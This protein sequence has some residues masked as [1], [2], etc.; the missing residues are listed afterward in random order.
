MRPVSKYKST[1]VMAVSVI[2]ALWPWY[3]L[4]QSLFSENAL[5]LTFPTQ[6]FATAGA[7]Y[8]SA[9]QNTQINAARL[10]HAEIPQQTRFQAKRDFELWKEVVLSQSQ[11]VKGFMN[12]AMQMT[13][14]PQSKAA[15]ND[16][17]ANVNA[18][19]VDLKSYKSDLSSYSQL[20]SHVEAVNKLTTF[21]IQDIHAADIHTYT[22]VVHD[23]TR[24]IQNIFDTGS[25]FLLIAIIA[26]FFTSRSLTRRSQ[27]IAKQSVEIEAAQRTA[28]ARAVLIGMVSH[29]L[30][31]PL[32]TL[33]ASLDLIRVQDKDSI[34]AATLDRAQA[35]LALMSNELRTL[36][37]FAQLTT[38]DT[39]E[40]SED[41][42]VSS[43]LRN[44]IAP[45]QDHA[46]QQARS[47]SLPPAID[48][49][50][51]SV[52]QTR[53][54]QIL[55]NFVSNALKYG[56]GGDIVLTCSLGNPL[57]PSSKRS[58]TFSVINQG[59]PISEKDSNMIWEPY[60]RIDKTS[61]KAPG[62]GLGL[63]VV[64]LLADTAGWDIGYTR[65]ASGQ[66]SFHV[67]LDISST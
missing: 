54:H 28:H 52:D 51:I 22:K 53:L 1:L 3:L 11:Y 35:S 34:H 37:Q 59:P 14:D 6:T 25:A 18:V 13:D 43:F 2:F 67:T 50:V 65:L 41:V 7:R 31:T 45:Y 20:A 33:D 4:R 39:H 29:E 12:H 16:I 63:S 55:D 49:L 27:S 44:I 17:I 42:S 46:T 19:D 61:K 15:I 47:F 8:L 57:K 9:L 64:R 21:A 5:S 60:Y 58:I 30:R 10:L 24:V 26:L 23:K 62:T 66:N 40:V 32:Q 36:T 48:D 56:T 38:G